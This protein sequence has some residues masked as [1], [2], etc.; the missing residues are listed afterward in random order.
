[1]SKNDAPP[2][3]AL[4]FAGRGHVDLGIQPAHAVARDLSIEA[5]IKVA[6]Q[7]DWAGVISKIFDNGSTES[8]YG[9]LLDGASGVK[10]GLKTNEHQIVYLSSGA[11]SISL[12]TWHHVAMTYDGQ[13]LAVYIDGEERATKALVASS[14][15]YS[16]PH[17]LHIGEFKDSDE[18]HG[19]TGQISEVR[20]WGCCRSGDQ[21]AGGRHLRL[22][23]DEDELVGYWPLDTGQG[24]VA[25]NACDEA[26]VCAIADATWVHDFPPFAPMPTPGIETSTGLADYS[27]W[28]QWK[29]KLAEEELSPGS[30]VTFRRG[31]IWC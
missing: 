25:R 23:G 21:I 10:C 31:R 3:S 4:S 6:A 1:M 28:W 20:L 17:Y 12:N 5:W 14:I 19:F 15:D 16:P 26:Q 29:E 13:R 27:Y 11:G 8:G 7:E 2:Q 30:P 18:R 22:R 24:E 9:V